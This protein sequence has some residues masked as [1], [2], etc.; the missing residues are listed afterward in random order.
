[1]DTFPIENR[2][3]LSAD[4]F[5]LLEATLRGHRSMKHAFDCWLAQTP[6]LVADDMITQDEFSHDFVFRLGADRYL[7]YDA[8]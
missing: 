4:A 7:V 8:T 1:M 5:A 6:P 3:G 2:A